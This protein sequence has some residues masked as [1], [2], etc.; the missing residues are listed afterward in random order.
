MT[1]PPKPSTAL[2]LHLKLFIH[3]L[4]RFLDY[5]MKCP[6][7]TTSIPI[8]H[9]IH[10]VNYFGRDDAILFILNR[11][12]P[13]LSTLYQCFSTRCKTSQPSFNNSD[14]FIAVNDANQRSHQEV[15]FVTWIL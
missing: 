14:I 7:S 9:R 15:E 3:Q 6:I 10:D 11:H 4:F 5:L 12:A 1:D 2:V 13:H 8:E